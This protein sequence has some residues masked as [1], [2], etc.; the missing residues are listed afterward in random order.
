MNTNSTPSFPVSKQGQTIW[1]TNGHLLVFHRPSQNTANNSTIGHSIAVN[2]IDVYISSAE[3]AWTQVD[4][5]DMELF[6]E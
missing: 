6:F 1:C 4:F 5:I 3:L 2:A